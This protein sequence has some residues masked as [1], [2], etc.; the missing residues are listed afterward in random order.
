MS[1]L[2]ELEAYRRCR[3]PAAVPE[4][5]A[6]YVPIALQGFSVLSTARAPYPYDALRMPLQ[7]MVAGCNIAAAA[8]LANPFIAAA[9][10]AI[11]RTTPSE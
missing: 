5:E 10:F 6:S 7:M 3:L 11:L 4:P 2:V 1:E 9:M 8:M